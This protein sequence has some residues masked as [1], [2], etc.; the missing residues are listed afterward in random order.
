[1]PN[2][3]KNK[4]ILLGVSGSIACYKAVDLASKLTQAGAL[5]DVILTEAAMEFVAPLT[6]QSITGRCAYTERDLWGSEGHVLHIGLGHDADLVVIA[7]ATANTLAKLAHGLA[8]NLL[9]LSVLAAECPII[10]APA[11]DGGMFN[12][13][14]TQDNL[15]KLNQRGYIQV[16]PEEGHLASGI[17]GIGRMVE[18]YKLVRHIRS[19]LSRGGPLKG[20]KIVVTAGGTQ[21]PIDPVRVISNR[22]SGK[23]GYAL[24]QAALDLGAEVTLISAPVHLHPPMGTR[25][26]DVDTAEDMCDA[27][28]RAVQDADA[29]LMAAAVADFKPAAA[30]DQKIK[31]GEGVKKF[32]VEATVDILNQVAKHKS[33]AGFPKYTV[34]FAAESQDLLENARAKL[35]NKGLDL[36]AAND[37]SAQDAGFAVDTNRVTLID[38][39]GMVE[40]LPLMSKAEVADAVLDRVVRSLLGVS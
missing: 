3:I 28:L 17:A 32:E 14:A 18:P 35:Q 19:V 29:L 9:T 11:M 8:D 40:T 21:E 39:L 23:Q 27:V 22:S 33:K 2:P 10:I 34:G 1:M 15:G 24:A 4:N 30:K 36:I 38:A 6:F 13:Q 37:I 7:P 12:N 16:G 20:R 25:M 26:I 5:V 31:K